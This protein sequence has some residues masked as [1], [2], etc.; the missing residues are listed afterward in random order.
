[1][2]HCSSGF[3]FRMTALT[4]VMIFVLASSPFMVFSGSFCFSL[5][6]TRIDIHYVS[7]QWFPAAAHSPAVNRLPIPS[8]VY[9]ASRRFGLKLPYQPL[10][11]SLIWLYLPR[12]SLLSLLQVLRSCSECAMI[13]AENTYQRRQSNSLC[14]HDPL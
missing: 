14:P 5:C 10:Q 9:A 13:L 4:S 3:S 12:T 6:L 8:F 11:A 7:I 2:V 1:M